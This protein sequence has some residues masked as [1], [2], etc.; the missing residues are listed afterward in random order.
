MAVR[1]VIFWLHLVAGIVAG[2]VILI[3]S[4]TGAALAFE[5]DLVAW[6]EQEVRK[7]AAPAPGAARLGLD[8][9]LSRAKEKASGARPSAVTVFADPQAAVFMNFGRTNAFYANPYTGELSGQGAQ[10]TRAFMHVMTDWHRWLGQDG[11]GR[12][13]GKAMTGVCNVAFLFLAVSGIYLW[14]PRKWSWTALKGIVL[15]NAKL[16]GKA[17]D[18]NWHNV[19]GIWSAP[20]LV[21]LTATAMVI[22]YKWASDMVYTVTGNTPPAVAG[23]GAMSGP[24]VEV[25]QPAPGTRPLGYETLIAAVQKEMPNWEQISIRFG[26]GPGQGPRSGRG[27]PQAVSISVREQDG[28]PLFASVQLSLD[29]FTGAILKKESYADYNSGRKARTWMRFLHTGEALGFFGK[30]VAGLA[31]LG[32]AVLVWTG[33]ALAWRRFVA[34]RRKPA[35]TATVV[36]AREEV[37]VS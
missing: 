13:V 1:K 32:G 34:W 20:V 29:P 17:R 8:E 36:E 22:S 11:D 2:I 6:A 3:M 15:F 18:W 10:S 27:A 37:S 12:A 23:P 7:I 9:L 14:W 19:I 4:V 33:F 35:A 28:W 5:K 16:S 24:A 30:L 21:I 26:G 25:P 31:S